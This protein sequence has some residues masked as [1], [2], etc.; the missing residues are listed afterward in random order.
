MADN[1]T[2]S[3]R[4]LDRA[5]FDRV[6]A[7]AAELQSSSVDSGDA[8]G[9]L[10]EE[11]I[12]D[13]GR[14][15]G[16]SVDHIRQAIAEERTRGASP[17]ERGLAAAVFGAARVRASRV[18]TGPPDEILDAIGGWMLR[19]EGLQLK[20]RVGDRIVWEPRRDIFGSLSRALNFGG[21]GYAL[22]RAAEVSATATTVDTTRSLVA[23]DAGL[24]EHRGRLAAGTAAAS[25]AGV[26]ATAIGAMV[27]VVPAALI[28][29]AVVAMGVVPGVALAISRKSQASAVSRGQLAL[30]QLL[31]H[32]ERGDHRRPGGLLGVITATAAAL[33][34]RR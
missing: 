29:V 6:L 9:M 22:T 31:D 28:A 18:V 20:R 16:M 27:I 15:A 5:A 32:L 3:P 10:T 21:R 17:D 4:R 23:L 25:T 34:G 2:P 12:I 14:E 26:A 24:A 1:L 13:L 7:R 33:Q 30:E 8:T 19:E 11:Q